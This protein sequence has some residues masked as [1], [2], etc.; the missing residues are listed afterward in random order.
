MRPAGSAGLP[1]QFNCH[2]ARISCAAMRILMLS[3]VY[4]PRVNGVSASMRT[5]AR[6][7]VRRGHEVTVVAPSYGPEDQSEEFE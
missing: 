3:D 2:Q 6:D 5:F 1:P 4:F 7:L